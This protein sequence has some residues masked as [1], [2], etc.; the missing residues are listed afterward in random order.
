MRETDAKPRAESSSPFFGA[1]NIPNRPY[2]EAPFMTVDHLLIG[3]GMA[4][5]RESPR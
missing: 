2:L 4:P 1:I 3:G 5:R